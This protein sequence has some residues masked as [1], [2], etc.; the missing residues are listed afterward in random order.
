MTATRR[1]LAAAISAAATL[2]LAAP[3]DAATV[4]TLPCVPVVSTT[5]S[6]PN[7]P[8]TGAGFTPGAMVT[9]RYASVQSPT[10]TYLTSATADPAGNFSVAAVAPLFAKFDTQ[11]QTFGHQRDRRRQPGARRSGAVQAGARRLHDQPVDGQAESHGDAHRARL[12]ARQEHLPALPLQRSDEAQRQGRQGEHAVRDRLPADGGCCRRARAPARGR[13][14]PIR[15][16]R[17]PRRRTPQLK[18][19]FVIRR[20]FG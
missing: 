9:I 15:R 7:M 13:S 16:R 6:S 19:S 12:R 5:S 18:Y 10:P 11:L 20:T 4:A 17:T 3:A 1:I 8:I 14:T 2:A